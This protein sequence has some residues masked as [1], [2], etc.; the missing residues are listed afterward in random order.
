MMLYNN[1]ETDSGVNA[2][3]KAFYQA[4]DTSGGYVSNSQIVSIIFV[5]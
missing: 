3:F 1:A 5:A 4:H 2:R